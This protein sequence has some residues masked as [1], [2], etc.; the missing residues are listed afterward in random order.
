MLLG[1]K[2]ACPMLLCLRAISRL[3]LPVPLNFPRPP[4]EKDKREKRIKT[5]DSCYSE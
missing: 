2:G 5:L 1:L 3:F 4:M